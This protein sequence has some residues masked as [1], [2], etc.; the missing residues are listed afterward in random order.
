MKEEIFNTDEQIVSTVRTG[1]YYR[2]DWVFPFR[3]YV[4]EVVFVATK[5]AIYKL[6]N[7]KLPN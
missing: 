7:Q 4:K 6:E 2:W 1:G 3:H 5:K